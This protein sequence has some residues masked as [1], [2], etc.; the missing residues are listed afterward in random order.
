MKSG[1]L[2]LR[3]AIGICKMS[4]TSWQTEKLRMNED[5]AN[6]VDYDPISVREQSRLHQFGKKVLPGILLGYA[7]IAEVIWEGNI[8]IADLE[9]VEKLDASDMYLRR[10]SA[11]EALISQKG[12]EFMSPVGDDTTKLSVRD[13]E[14]REPTLRR[15][16]TVRSEDFSGELQGESEESHATESTDDAEARADFW[17]MHGVF[18]YRHNDEPRVQIYVPKEKT[19]PIPL[20]YIDVT[21][22]TQT[23]LDVMQEKRLDDFG[24]SI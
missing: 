23:D 4:K 16:P 15:E 5:L 18:I 7:L 14:F 6:L 10:I 11:K 3:N 2:I 13:Y 24:M 22:S 17:S 1:G 20:K 21:R 8:L 19:F 12:D 9:E